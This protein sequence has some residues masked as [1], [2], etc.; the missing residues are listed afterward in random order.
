MDVLI[1]I[2]SLVGI[3]LFASE[4]MQRSS[5]L[6]PL[7]AV[8]LAMLWITAFGCVGL[9]WLGGWLWYGLAVGA[10]VWLLFVKKRRISQ[11]FSPG[12]LFFTIGSVFFVL[13]F[14][15]TSPLFTQWDEFTFWGMAGK[16]LVE[17]NQLY[18]MVQ[19]NLIARSYPPGLPAFGYLMQFFGGVFGSFGEYKLMVA[20]AIVYLAAFSAASALWGKNKAGATVMLL[21]LFLLPVFFEINVP[22]GQMFYSYLSVMADVP[23]AALFGGA[24][25]IYYAGGTKSA[26]LWLPFCVVLAALVNIK[27]IGLALAMIALFMALLDMALC[28]R[29][30]LYFWKFRRWKAWF[31]CAVSGL[32]F[33]LG[34]Y[35]VWA[36]HLK[37][38][39]QGINRFD[40]G[41]KGESLG[42]FE[43][44][45]AGIKALFGIQPNEKFSDIAK[46]M[47]DAFFTRPI[48]LLGSSVMVMVLIFLIVAVTW[49]L[50]G[51]KRQRLRVTVFFAGMLFCFVAFYLF[52]I[53]TYTFILQNVESYAL[54]DF[55]RYMMPYWFGWLMGA[56]V[57]LSRATQDEK[58]LRFR[59]RAARGVS[60]VLSMVLLATVLL[61]GNNRANFLRISPSLYTHRWDVQRVVAQAKSEG[62]QPEDVVYTI[63]QGDD[64]SR[65]YIFSY[66]LQARMSLLFEG[67]ETDEKGNLVLDE[68]GQPILV[69]NTSVSFVA[70]GHLASSDYVF[71]AEI[72]PE[73]WA[74]FLKQQ[75]C[76]HVLLDVVDEYILE[77][78]GPLFSDE[79]EGWSL[80]DGLQTGRRYYKILWQGNTMRLVPVEGGAAE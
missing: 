57:L 22:A 62:M 51:T 70:P 43:M 66:E 28:E 59:L 44:L 64:S 80:Q 9:L 79:L 41:S 25:C 31:L 8:S 71:K 10:W 30:R 26:K 5:A 17:N 15:A 3:S 73:N 76:T 68:K 49:M 46:L 60:A 50:S 39:P 29:D 21:G 61:L 78:F 33:T 47:L 37:F 75:G 53:F 24:L 27:D 45:T 23:L 16:V 56:V 77:E 40:V 19:S 55:H 52:N 48:F 4:K 69:G 58:S 42:Q 18:T 2:A 7:V 14:W 34:S 12:L 67:E 72:T 35:L 13:L 54:K 20:Y 1:G 65:F 38:S 11:L 74:K 36:L 63:S 6:G 32:L